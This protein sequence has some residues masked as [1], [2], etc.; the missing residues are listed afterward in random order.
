MKFCLPLLLVL[1]S[2]KPRVEETQ[3]ELEF[4]CRP[5]LETIFEIQNLRNIIRK[6][7]EITLTEYESGRVRKETW[8]V[9]RDSWLEREN[10]LAGEVNQLYIYSYETK[11]LQ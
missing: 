4:R 8:Q 7:F 6:D 10:Q 11:C 9:E 5:V 2:C 1:L 3:P